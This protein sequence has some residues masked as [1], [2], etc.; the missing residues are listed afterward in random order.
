MLDLLYQQTQAATAAVSMD[1]SRQ[2]LHQIDWRHRLVAIRG[3]RGVG[4][5]T[6]ML[7]HL[8]QTYGR[9]KEALYTT[10]DDFFFSDIRLIDLARDFHAKGGKA[11]YL[12]EVHKYPYDNWAQEI[13]NIYDLLPS[14]KVVF[15]GSSILKILQEQADLSRRALIYDL[16]GLSFREY[17]NLTQGTQLPVFVWEDI[18]GRHEE[19]AGHILHDHQIHPLQFFAE[20]LREGY[21][22]FFLENRDIYPQRVRELL[23]LIIEIDLNYLPEHTITDHVK[24]NRLLYAIA[25]SAPFKPNI[26]KL[27]E[28]VELNR[29][30]LTQYIYILERARMLNLLL[31][32]HKGVSS[33]QNPKKFSWKIRTS[34]SPWPPEK[35]TRAV[36]AKRSSSTNS[37]RHNRPE[38]CHSSC[39]TPTRAISW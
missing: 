3:A 19:I 24:I 33:L 17:L 20:Y 9:S 13:K 23:K 25:S 30:R 16:Q 4:K 6:L 12:D 36:F 28:R 7:Q 27:S 37:G 1:Y 21:Y 31:S 2:L 29:N 35:Q 15:S 26:S 5:T 18:I 8:R 34:H 38:A 11:I 10:L 22:P 39:L 14:L 32:R